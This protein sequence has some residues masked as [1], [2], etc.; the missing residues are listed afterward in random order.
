MPAQFYQGPLMKQHYRELVACYDGVVACYDGVV[1]CYD[2]VVA[3]YDG[4]VVRGGRGQ[5]QL[6]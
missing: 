6:N 4:V 1:A 3:C 5:S 2:G